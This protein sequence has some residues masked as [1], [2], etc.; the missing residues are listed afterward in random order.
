MQFRGENSIPD[1][2]QKDKQDTQKRER[3]AANPVIPNEFLFFR[4]FFS[5]SKEKKRQKKPIAL[6][7]PPL[8]AAPHRRPRRRHGTGC[9]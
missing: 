4:R 2:C 5:L 8:Y 6:T 1:I 7:A 9:G 3:L